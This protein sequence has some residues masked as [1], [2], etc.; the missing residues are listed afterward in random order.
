[1]S[2]PELVIVFLMPPSCLKRMVFC[3]E[4]MINAS[5]ALLLLDTY[6]ALFRSWHVFIPTHFY[7]CCLVVLSKERVGNGLP[8]RREQI[9][10]GWG[11]LLLQTR[12]C[13]AG[14][15]WII[16]RLGIA[17]L[18]PCSSLYGTSFQFIWNIVPSYLESCSSLAIPSRKVNK[19]LYGA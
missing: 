5:Y 12:K 19:A 10:K 2:F 4:R 1:M 15:Q 16:F 13:V 11:R 9:E 7:K 18:E 6:V 14:N 17:K 3:P 8:I